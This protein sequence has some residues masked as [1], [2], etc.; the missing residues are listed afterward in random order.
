MVFC[1]GVADG[2]LSLP[3]PLSGIWAF[4]VSELAIPGAEVGRI[5]ATDAD[6]GDNAKLEYTILE[7]ET[8][9]TFNITGQDQEAVIL[10]NKVRS[11][12]FICD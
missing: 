9:D 1:V 4:S 7:G 2:S 10:L 3:P 12:V 11:S 5:S 6:L 8:G